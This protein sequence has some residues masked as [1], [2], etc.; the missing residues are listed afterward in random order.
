[1]KTM[2]AF[3]LMMAF[4]FSGIASAQDP[5]VFP[6][7]GQGHEQ[8]EKDKFSCY[9]WA[10]KETGFDPMKTPTAST[11]PPQQRAGQGGALKGAAVGA[12][13]GALIKRK[14]SRSKGAAT[15]A[16]IGGVLGG[17]RQS[18]RNRQDE[19]ARQQWEQQQANEY[20]HKRNTYNR[21]FSASMESKGYTV[22]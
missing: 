4:L 11:P 19:Q 9:Q 21:A 20:A 14:D 22:K 13:A 10:K 17:A 8:M 7:K 5:I 16:A 3:I 6:A 1:M 18:R 2:F 15:G 12:G